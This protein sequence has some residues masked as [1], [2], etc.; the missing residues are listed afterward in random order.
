M[1]LHQPSAAMASAATIDA[2][3]AIERSYPAAPVQQ[4]VLADNQHYDEYGVLQH[5]FVW[6]VEY[7]EHWT[8]IDGTP[9]R[10]SESVAFVDAVTGKLLF[11]ASF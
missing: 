2:Q 9:G 8:S 10:L 4:A 5:Q 1:F 6:A 7:P 11:T 3:T